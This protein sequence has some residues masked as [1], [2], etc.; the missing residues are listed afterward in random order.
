VGTARVENLER[1]ARI[2]EEGPL[3][4][5]LLA[6]INAAWAEHGQVWGG[7]V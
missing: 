5:E 7:E 6:Q 2:V 1:N 4:A 3:P